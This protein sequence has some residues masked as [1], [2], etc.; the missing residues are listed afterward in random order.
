MFKTSPDLLIYKWHSLTDSISFFKPPVSPD[1]TLNPG[2]SRRRSACRNAYRFLS[3]LNIPW[4]GVKTSSFKNFCSKQKRS[5]LM[6]WGNWSDE[7]LVCGAVLKIGGS[8]VL[9]WRLGEELEPKQN[10]AKAQG[11]FE[12]KQ[13]VCRS[14]KKEKNKEKIEKKKNRNQKIK[15]REEVI[16]R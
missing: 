16:K 10:E 14:R 7:R 2:P 1:P 5:S 6:F 9:P 3:A 13:M 15:N 12:W 4:N 11:H 8:T